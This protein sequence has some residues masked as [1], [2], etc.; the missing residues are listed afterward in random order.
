MDVGDWEGVWEGVREKDTVLVPSTL[1]D[2]LDEDAPL[3]LAT[4]VTLQ[5]AHD[6]A[7]APLGVAPALSEP[8]DV[9]GKAVETGEDEDELLKLTE[10]D[11]ERDRMLL[12]LARV[13]LLA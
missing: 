2:S 6:D 1:A 13:E 11:G 10:L 7:V 8:T 4:I 12:T 3:P 5:L 9:L